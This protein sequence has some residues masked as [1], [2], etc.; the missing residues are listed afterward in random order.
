MFRNLQYSPKTLCRDSNTE[1]TRFVDSPGSMSP[2][3]HSSEGH[4]R[5][6]ITSHNSRTQSQPNR[7]GNKLFILL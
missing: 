3:V 6:R 7:N 2:S 1:R 5:S 4:P